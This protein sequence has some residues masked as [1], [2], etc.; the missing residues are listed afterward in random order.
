MEKENQQRVIWVWRSISFHTFSEGSLLCQAPVLVIQ[1]RIRWYW[2]LALS[3]VKERLYGQV[4]KKA[5]PSEAL[6][7]QRNRR[8]S[9]CFRLPLDLGYPGRVISAGPYKTLRTSSF[10]PRVADAQG[11]MARAGSCREHMPGST[12][13]PDGEE[14]T[15]EQDQD[16]HRTLAQ[17]HR[18]ALHLHVPPL[19]F[20]HLSSCLSLCGP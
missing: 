10:C 11:L 15:S 14:M 12:P 3:P 6:K 2:A 19:P 5:S 18:P 1:R 9:N 13:S 17:P 8:G 20:L 16:W 7:E 4:T